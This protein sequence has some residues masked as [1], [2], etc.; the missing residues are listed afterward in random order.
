MTKPRVSR[1]VVDIAMATADTVF[2]EELIA[3]MQEVADHMAGKR[4][5]LVTHRVKIEPTDVKAA[6][7]AI[8]VTQA[9]F[10]ELVGAPLSTVRSWEQGQRQP[11]GAARTLLKVIEREPAAVKRALQA[12]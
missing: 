7:K 12:R 11:S 5:D 3:A 6:R 8:G 9:K 4:P 10:A 1:K 2:G